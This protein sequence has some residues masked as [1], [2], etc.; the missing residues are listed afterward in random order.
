M[1]N[2]TQ[3]QDSEPH[4]SALIGRFYIFIEICIVLVL[5][6]IFYVLLASIIGVPLEPSTNPISVIILYI[7]N[8]LSIVLS[9][10]VGLILIKYIFRTKEIVPNNND[11]SP[12]SETF[13]TFKIK[14]NN[15]GYQLL[16]GALFLFL[17]YIPMD[18]IAYSIPGVLDFS[19]S[20]LGAS[21]VNVYLN[22]TSFLLFIGYCVLIHLCVGI[23]E[24]L[25]FRGVGVTRARRYIGNYPAVVIISIFFG[26]SHF[27]YLLTSDNLLADFLPAVIWG[28]SAFV[29]GSASAL[30][31]MK[32]RYIIPLI[33][34]HTLNNIISAS[35]VW[36]FNQGIQF[37]QIA[38][39]VYLPLLI[40]SAILFIIFRKHVV[41]GL[42]N[43]KNIIP[44]YIKEIK[45]SKTNIF[46]AI[47]IDL[48]IGI[49]LWFVGSFLF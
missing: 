23:R 30:F 20:A 47:V 37:S 18:F 5:N 38:Q 19:S 28:L 17:I 31:I 40:I 24:E 48:L 44:E 1:S 12:I 14:K 43:Y 11:K 6:A 8:L 42:R 9:S 33:F 13:S 26:F 32:K 25:F 45:Q 46:L 39:S 21:D 49:M 41:S 16:Y 4:E 27:S 10:I 3:N 34:A 35:A 29:A 36:M 7:E 22:Y 15:I 2:I